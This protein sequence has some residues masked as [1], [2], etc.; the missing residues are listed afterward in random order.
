MPSRAEPSQA[1]P[2]RAKPSRAE[3]SRAKPSKARPSQAKRNRL[4]CEREQWWLIGR[5]WF[6]LL[7][8]WQNHESFTKTIYKVSDPDIF[9][10]IGYF[11]RFGSRNVSKWASRQENRK[12]FINNSVKLALNEDLYPSGDITSNLIKK[13]SIKTFKIIANQNGIVGGIEFAKSTFKLFDSKI[14]FQIRKKDGS[15]IKKGS[16]LSNV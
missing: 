16:K 1:E 3:P 5:A 11:H 15:Q 2:S 10:E 14:Q 12:S 8:F 4:D 9:V 6:F 7:R 13:S